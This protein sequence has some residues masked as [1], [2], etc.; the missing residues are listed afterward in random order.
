[1]HAWAALNVFWID[2]RQRG[3]L[4]YEF[5]ER[6]FHKLLLNF[7]WWVNR[8]DAEGNNVF[9]GGFLGL[10]NIG[11][12]N[13]SEALPVDAVLEQ[14]DGSG[15][16]AMYCL[17]LLHVSLILAAHNK[18][19]EDVA[20]K[21]F[22]HFSL[23]AEAMTRTG[24]WS[25]EDGFF[26][27]VVRMRDGSSVPLKIR[28]MV[29]IVPVVALISSTTSRWPD[30]TRSWPVPLVHRARAHR[31]S[32]FALRAR[33]APGD[34]HA[35]G[36]HPTGCVASSPS[37]STRTSSSPHGLRSLSKHHPITRCRSTRRRPRRGALRAGES[38]RACSAAT[39]PA[40]PVWFLLNYLF[41]E[42]LRFAQF[43]GTSSRWST[44]RARAPS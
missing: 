20:V 35:V 22:E 5:L 1:V 2:G 13:R 16:M 43:V 9:E 19:Y 29:G 4:D 8:E 37:C 17:N 42:K 6:I 11:P 44:P 39:G 14:S 18:V 23:I 32:F 40:G 38:T 12:F 10:D 26:F 28:S 7:T 36:D 15:W 25:E 3:E 34:G 33:R 30:S 31:D 24:L 41:V 27:D 21:F